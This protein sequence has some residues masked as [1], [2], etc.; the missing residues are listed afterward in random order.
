MAWASLLTTLLKLV[1]GLSDYLGR[2]QLLEAG[3]AEAVSAGLQSILDNLK[4]AD[5]VK[6]EFARNPDGSFAHGV[7]DKYT[8]PDE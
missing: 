3:K 7:R 8:R 1:A 2:Q 6:E 4:K 5:D